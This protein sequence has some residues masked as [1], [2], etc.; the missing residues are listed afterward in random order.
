VHGERAR[1][2]VEIEENLLRIGQEALSNAVRHA[3]PAQVLVEL[4]YEPGR[5]RLRVNDDGDGFAALDRGRA[6]GLGVAIM[7][8]RAASIGGL[9]NI[10]SQ[11]GTGTQ[12]EAV[13]P[14][15]GHSGEGVEI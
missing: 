2:P 1:L 12:V 7:K 13:V 10:R 11:P 8:G 6:S 5:V 9:L 14:T 15:Q 4:R 3:K